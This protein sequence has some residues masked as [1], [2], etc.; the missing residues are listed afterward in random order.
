MHNANNLFEP[1]FDIENIIEHMIGEPESQ[2]ELIRIRD[3][4]FEKLD[5]IRARY[6]ELMAGDLTEEEKAAET[7]ALVFEFEEAEKEE[8]RAA[9]PVLRENV[10][11]MEQKIARMEE[12]RDRLLYENARLDKHRRM[13]AAQ[14]KKEMKIYPNDPCPC[15]SGK[16]FKK[17]CGK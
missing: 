4:F 2:D 7:K 8:L 16:K 11:G 14:L 12:Q 6:E 9:I 3:M 10:S 13:I 15:G 17:C 5:E 1:G